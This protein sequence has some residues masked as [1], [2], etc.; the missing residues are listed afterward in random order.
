MKKVF[1]LSLLFIICNSIPLWSAEDYPLISTVFQQQRSEKEDII[2]FRNKDTLRGQVVNDRLSM[3]T[4]YG[5]VNIPVHMC[6]GISFEGS[7]NNTETVVTV[8]FNRFTGIIT[9]KTIKFKHGSSG[10]VIPVRKEK[11]R[12]IL[13]KKDAN[14][15][16]L[17]GNYPQSDLF[18][19]TNGDLLSG[20]LIERKITVSTDNARIP[21]NLSDIKTIKINSY[22]NVKAV[23][24]RTTGEIIQGS[25][26]TDEISIDLEMG[27]K[28]EAVYKDKF[29]W[30]FVDQARSQA[31]T[32]FAR[33]AP[34]GAESGYVSFTDTGT[35]GK[36]I[37]VNLEP[38]LGNRGTRMK[39]A[40]IPAGNFVMGSGASEKDRNDDEV[41]VREVIVSNNFY[42]GIYEVTQEQY[43]A[44]MGS[45]PGKFSDLNNPVE[46][47][48]WEHAILFCKRM[49]EI[50]K[51]EVTLPTEAE[52][53]YAARAGSRTRFYFGDNEGELDA[54]AWYKKNSED[55][56]HPAGQ[57]KPNAFGLYDMHGNV[58]EWCIDWYQGNYMN[59]AGKDPT[60]PKS[61]SHR[62]I[63]G[64]GWN[65]DES[66]CRS[67]NREYGMPGLRNSNLGFR[68]V[69]IPSGSSRDE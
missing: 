36:T 21:V 10:T 25:I 30:V 54:C 3:A 1:L 16:S 64:G 40:L 46:Q 56:T 69:I 60:G 65:S 47:V 31:P 37:E 4:Q 63:R 34:A 32:R 43:I 29:N 45:N 18:V 61:G 12:Y 41:P 44:V 48:S 7:Q 39:L 5:M 26:D 55:K 19:M 62:V 28:I 24:T 50:T 49:S 53:E 9:D 22:D 57:K 6:A 35:P 20:E 51:M 58:Y 17:Q 11:I 68:V 66:I 59:L 33:A 52:W 27:S 15:S 67:A 38:S 13:L 8:N 23:I 2:I 14:E 42:M